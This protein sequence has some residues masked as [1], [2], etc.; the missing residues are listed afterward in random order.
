MSSRFTTAKRPPRSPPRP[1]RARWS[2]HG[3]AD[4]WCSTIAGPS[5][6]AYMLALKTTLTGSRRCTAG[7]AA[8]RGG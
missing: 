4:R 7:P 5:A 3:P 8:A 6:A 2:R 1:P